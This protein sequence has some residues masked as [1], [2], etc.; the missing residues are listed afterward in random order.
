MFVL[1][2][3]TGLI[4]N[5]SD[6]SLPLTLPFSSFFLR[7][8]SSYEKSRLIGFVPLH[9][10]FIYLTFIENLC[11]FKFQKISWILESLYT[12]KV[13]YYRSVFFNYGKNWNENEKV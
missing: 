11:L 8:V 7:T 6:T 1:G 5:F 4:R 9:H 10:L 13:I 3:E 2:G 12:F